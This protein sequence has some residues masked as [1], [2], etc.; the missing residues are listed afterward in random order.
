LNHQPFISVCA[1]A[2]ELAL[3]FMH[4]QLC[5]PV[6][7]SLLHSV[8]HMRLRLLLLLLLLLQARS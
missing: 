2:S 4:N 6:P 7:W 5:L 8:V 1:F 3:F